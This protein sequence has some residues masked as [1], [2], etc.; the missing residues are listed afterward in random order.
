[1]KR[2]KENTPLP[3]SPPLPVAAELPL[4][5]GLVKQLFSFHDASHRL[6]KLL[7]K[8]ETDGLCT[9]IRR[10]LCKTLLMQ[11]R[12]QKHVSSP[13]VEALCAEAKRLARETLE[14]EIQKSDDHASDI[15]LWDKKTADQIATL[16]E[17]IALLT[18][19]IEED[20]LAMRKLT[21]QLSEEELRRIASGDFETTTVE[22]EP[23][24]RK[25]RYKSPEK[26]AIAASAEER[27]LKR[28]LQRE[29]FQKKKREL[30]PEGEA[31]TGDVS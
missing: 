19:A 12:S 28:I 23:K 4:W 30:V 17:T 3:D 31:E 20:E 6:K 29:E 10:N 22:W 21:R 16:A 25:L 18:L 13:E 1:M 15:R 26:R 9:L 5:Q 11:R 7:G 24:E 14:H 8:D 27:R 2:Q